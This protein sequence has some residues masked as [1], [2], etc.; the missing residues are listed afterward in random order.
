MSPLALSGYYAILDV[1]DDGRADLSVQLPRAEALLAARPTCLQVRGKRLVAAG[2]RDLASALRPLCVRA[3]VPLCVNDRLDVALAVEADAVHLGQDDLP[4]EEARRI[5]ARAGVRLAIGVSTHTLAQARA[6]A[7]ADYIGFG[8]VFATRTKQNPDPVVGPAAL[9]QVT[10]AVNVP[11]V[12]IGGIDFSNL[13]AVVQAGVA[14]AAVIGAVD[15]ADD[16]TA[17]GRR[18][19]AAFAAR[20]RA[21]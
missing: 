8:P 7:G 3:G 11:V 18:V 15:R 17:A 14:A 20:A 4:L 13:D 21:A 9:A 6:A 12:A 10:A 16:R 19:G 5:V 2:L 1:P